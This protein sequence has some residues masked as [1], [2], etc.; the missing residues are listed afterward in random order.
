MKDSIFWERIEWKSYPKPF[1]L[2]ITKTITSTDSDLISN[3]SL[4]CNETLGVALYDFPT[5]ENLITEGRLLDLNF[6]RGESLEG[7]TSQIQP[8]EIFHANPK[9]ISLRTLSIET[10]T[11]SHRT[12]IEL[13]LQPEATWE[14]PC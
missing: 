14:Q 10:R 4:A 9:S 3:P 12:E 1:A 2:F 8:I 6:D 5:L 7:E 11:F 13:F